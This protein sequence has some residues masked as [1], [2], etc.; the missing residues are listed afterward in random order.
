MITALSSILNYPLI[1]LNVEF[2]SKS[3]RSDGKLIFDRQWMDEADNDDNSEHGSSFDVHDHDD[4]T[5]NNSG[6]KNWTK[7][8]INEKRMLSPSFISIQLQGMFI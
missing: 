2:Q 7:S 3:Y 1:Q 5:K 4:D 8:V 6:D